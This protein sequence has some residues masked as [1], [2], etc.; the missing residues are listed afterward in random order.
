MA[1]DYNPNLD[2]TV[3]TELSSDLYKYTINHGVYRNNI[4][5]QLLQ[6][7]KKLSNAQM[8]TNPDQAQFIA[9][10][11]LISGA[12]K[13]LE[14][15]VFTGYNILKIALTVANLQIYA[16]EKD[17]NIIKNI[18]NKYWKKAQVNDRI[19]TIIDD[20]VVSLS[21]LC[22][23]HN[24]LNSFDIAFIDANKND[25]PKYFELCYKL[26]RPH[27]IIMIDNTFIHGLVLASN[28][29]RPKYA[30]VIDELNKKLLN[31]DRVYISMLP[32][33]DGLTI[34]YKK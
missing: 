19:T 30:S 3:K 18:A 31:D 8:V 2:C 11:A 34:A 10:L 29:D 25:Y 28:Q 4:L 24:N 15:G 20:A 5:E 27:G 16:L 32:I 7:T 13:Y 14:V 17:P 26:V 9:Q 23:N 21:N 12:K 22:Q 1:F 6:E 33:H